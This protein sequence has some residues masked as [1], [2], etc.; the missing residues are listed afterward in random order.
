MGHLF[1]SL[2]DGS[3]AF[4]GKCTGYESE[5]ASYPDVSL[6]FFTFP[7]SLALHHQSLACHSRFA[8]TSAK[9]EAPMEEAEIEGYY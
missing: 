2:A 5:A 7:W 1:V 9:N 6:S 3:A 8:L 4:S